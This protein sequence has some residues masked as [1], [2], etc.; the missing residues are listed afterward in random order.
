MSRTAS[1][2]SRA[3]S[4]SPC[5]VVAWVG[6]VMAAD[7][8][9]H[10]PTH[11]ARC[12]GIAS[13]CRPSRTGCAQRTRGCTRARSGSAGTR[14]PRRQPTIRQPALTPPDAAQGAPP[15]RP[16]R[17]RPARRSA[18]SPRRSCSPAR[19]STL[20]LDALDHAGAQVGAS[21]QR[22]PRRAAGGHVCLPAGGDASLHIID[23]AHLDHLLGDH[24]SP[25]EV[26]L[27][28]RHTPT[29][30]RP[31]SHERLPAL[32]HDGG[33]GQRVGHL[34]LVAAPP[35]QLLKVST[36]VETFPVRRG[37]RVRACARSATTAAATARLS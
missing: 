11:Q 25:V 12:A 36:A 29:R 28:D 37:S 18:A 32:R 6:V 24:P 33:S 5:R 35:V 20:V 2:A 14:R 21:Q 34:R 22:T 4:R 23:G 7:H 31:R 10:G 8:L 1:R 27:L 17:R 15:A 3:A 26:M 30:G 13:C 19:P 9:P 16:G